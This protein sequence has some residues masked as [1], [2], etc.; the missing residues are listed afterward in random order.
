MKMGASMLCGA[1]YYTVKGENMLPKDPVILLSTVNTRLR[2]VYP[3]ID[4]L[5][6]EE[7]IAREE[8]DKTLEAIGYRYSEEQN[9]YV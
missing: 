1:Y 5:C 4:T 7:D 2:D 8:L 9:A 3:D 6:R